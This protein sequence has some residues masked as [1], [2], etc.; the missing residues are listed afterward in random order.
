MRIIYQ[1]LN[2]MKRTSTFIFLFV[3]VFQPVK[4]RAQII[5]QYIDSL[6]EVL[7][8]ERRNWNEASRL[9]IA[10]GELAVDPLLNIRSDKSIEEWP[11]RK[12]A[13][14]LA[15]IPSQRIDPDIRMKRA[16]LW[17]L[18]RIGPSDGTAFIRFLNDKDPELVRLAL[19][20]LNQPGN[21]KFR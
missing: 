14:T 15:D 2:K 13:F 1:I 12:A 18:S 21:E 16:S 11:R 8:R 3:F 6:V 4:L 7:V 9:L 5:Y 10:T 17:A 19:Y 20:G